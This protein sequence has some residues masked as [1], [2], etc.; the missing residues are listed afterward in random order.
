MDISNKKFLIVYDSIEYFMPFIKKENID[1]YRLYDDLNYVKRALKKVLQVLNIRTTFWYSDWKKQIS[2]YD[3]VIFFANRDFYPLHLISKISPSTKIFFWYWNPAIKMADPLKVPKELCEMWSYDP[4]D[5]EKYA[6]KFNT[7]FYFK[8]IQIENINKDI[9]LL[10]LGIDKGR[11]EVLSDLSKQMIGNNINI[12][13]HV[14]PDKK[15]RRVDSPLPISYMKYLELISRSKCILDLVP[16]DNNGMTLRPMEA[17]FLKRKLVTNDIKI[18][19]EPFY[20]P[21]NIFVL[22]M[23]DLSTINEFINSEYKT[24]DEKVIQMY[25]F[26]SW[27]SRFFIKELS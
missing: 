14:V 9:D 13:F 4:V 23:D 20:D 11:K 6:L 12:Y 18:I 26:E 7:T 17:L 27:L 2:S 1:V 15:D 3:Y 24:G 25:D 19:K 8:E 10:F 5:C 22:G 21:Q 16:S